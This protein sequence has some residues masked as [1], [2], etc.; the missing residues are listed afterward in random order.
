MTSRVIGGAHSLTS[1]QKG[2]F[3]R[4]SSAHGSQQLPAASRPDGKRP[5]YPVESA[6]T[7]ERS[8]LGWRRLKCDYTLGLQPPPEK[9]VGVGAMGV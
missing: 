1:S 7:R 6:R 4:P 2:S 9:M 5:G 3:M 8:F